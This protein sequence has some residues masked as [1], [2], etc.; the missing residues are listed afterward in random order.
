MSKIRGPGGALVAICLILGTGACSKQQEPPKTANNETQRSP[1]DQYGDQKSH[2]NSDQTSGQ[3]SNTEALT[4]T[5]EAIDPALRTVTL[6]DKEGH[7]FVIDAGPAAALESV[8]VGNEVQVRYKETVAFQLEDSK[9]GDANQEPIVEQ[10][11]RKQ[12]PDSVE[13]ARTIDANVEI[14]SVADDG[15]S[16]KVRIPHGEV[17]TIGID[18]PK[19]Q[20][21]VAQL[22]PGDNVA[23][24]YTEDLEVDIEK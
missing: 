10:S 8:K 19:S 5:V 6:R 3:M 2:P 18:D 12:W 9:Q 7:L 16:A 21:K 4:A 11:S 17:R 23:V 20:K 15:S 13:F 1:S 14:V 24:T 22:R